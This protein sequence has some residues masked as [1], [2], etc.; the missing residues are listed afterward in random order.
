MATEHCEGTGGVCH[1]LDVV[2][3][4][5]RV[6]LLADRALYWPRARTLFVAD[7]HLG[8]AAAF[9]AGGTFQHSGIRSLEFT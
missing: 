9:R 2:L 1:A 6:Q 7:V 4:D 5:E 8:K 3:C